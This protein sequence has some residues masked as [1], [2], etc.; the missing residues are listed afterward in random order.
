MGHWCVFRAATGGRF[1][2]RAYRGII[3]VP[4]PTLRRL[5]SGDPEQ[6]RALGER[7][8]AAA[9]AGDVF[10]LD[11]EFGSGKTVLVQGLALG[12]GVAT[13]VGSP[14][15]VIINEHVGRLRL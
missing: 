2:P 9:Q 8:G 7:L 4:E 10:L 1:S 6:T 14:S 5:V 11:G 15:F 12:L 3:S 13:P